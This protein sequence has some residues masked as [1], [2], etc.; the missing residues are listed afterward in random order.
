MKYLLSIIVV[1]L[2]TEIINAQE[3][4]IQQDGKEYDLTSV[5]FTDS[6]NGTAVGGHMIL[7]TSDGGETWYNDIDTLTSNIPWRCVS[8]V[9][10]AGVFYLC[11]GQGKIIKYENGKYTSQNSGTTKIL[12]SLS[13]V[14]NN[15]GYAVGQDGTI[16]K[17]TNGGEDWLPQQ[18]GTTAWLTSVNAIDENNVLAVG[19]SGYVLQTTNGGENWITKNIPNFFTYLACV[20][21]LNPDNGWVSGSEGALV[22]I[23][24][25]TMAVIHLQTND[26]I[27]G[28]GFADPNCAY[29]VGDNGTIVHFNGSVWTPEMSNTTNWLNSVTLVKEDSGKYKN[30]YKV[31]A[32]AVGAK[33]TIL[34]KV[35][36]IVKVENN[37]TPNEFYVSQNYPNPFNPSTKIEYLIPYT[38]LV[39]A[40]LY[41]ITGAVIKSLVNT[42][43][44]QGKYNL[45]ID[46]GSSEIKLSSGIYFVQF[47][48]LPIQ[49]NSKCIIKTNKIIL[50]K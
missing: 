31:Y 1:L 19:D 8:G 9:K 49:T 10:I 33:G 4:I 37:E 7:R 3:W 42:T 20:C 18:S 44:S 23:K 17:T 47:T 2:M 38:S 15:L 43:K 11:G 35:T 39:K 48:I 46:A 40:D 5:Y 13:F 41:D 26:G 27:M 36:T 28:L 30:S 24:P 45:T 21:L 6:Q 25:D 50:L 12:N 22:K 29:G 32:Y 16:L 14:T 34:K